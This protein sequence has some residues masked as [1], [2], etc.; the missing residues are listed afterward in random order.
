LINHRVSSEFGHFALSPSFF[1]CLSLLLIDFLGSHESLSFFLSF[2]L[3]VPSI[4]S[5]CLVDLLLSKFDRIGFV[6]DFF[7]GRLFL[8]LSIYRSVCLPS[9]F[10]IMS[11]P[12]LI[13]RT[14]RRRKRLTSLREPNW[15][16]GR[17]KEGKRTAVLIFFPPPPCF[18][19]FL[20]LSFSS[21]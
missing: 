17:L 4:L 15:A 6:S 19:F 9:S 21:T 2:V 10:K 16:G 12:S 20:F 18:S 7:V 3:S 8:C 14:R 13:M 5:V 1:V 11:L